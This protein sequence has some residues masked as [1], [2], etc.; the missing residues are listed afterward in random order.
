VNIK[1]NKNEQNELSLF[2]KRQQESIFPTTYRSASKAN[3][4]DS[5]LLILTVKFTYVCVDGQGMQ[6]HPQAA[7]I[8][9]EPRLTTTATSPVNTMQYERFR[10]L[11]TH[12]S[13][14]PTYPSSVNK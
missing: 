9:T 11:Q 10:C 13:V 2:Y 4:Q 12:F 7:W 8:T 1:T 5:N 14:Q 3:S 6:C